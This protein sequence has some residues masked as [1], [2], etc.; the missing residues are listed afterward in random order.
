MC[1]LCRVWLST[2]Q[3]FSAAKSMPILT[4]LL[5]HNGQ[6]NTSGVS[7]KACMSISASSTCRLCRANKQL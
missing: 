6:F 1:W 5:P 4:R 7:L 3:Q 2:G